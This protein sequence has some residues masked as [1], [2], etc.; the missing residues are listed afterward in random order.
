IV[1]VYELRDKGQ[2][3]FLLPSEQ[4]I[5]TAGEETLDSIIAITLKEAKTLKNMSMNLTP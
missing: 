5:L 4:I 2:Y 3:G 1:Y